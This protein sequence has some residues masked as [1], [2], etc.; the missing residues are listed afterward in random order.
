MTKVRLCEAL[1]IPFRPPPAAPVIHPERVCTRRRY[2]TYPNRYTRADLLAEAR[3][4]NIYV[5][6]GTTTRALCT[7]LG[8]PYIS[9]PVMPRMRPVRAPDAPGPRNV[10]VGAG[11]PSH[12]PGGCITR[13][14]LPLRAHQ[15]RVIEFMERSQRKGMMLFHKVGSGKTLTAIVASQCYLDRHPDGRVLV[16]TPTSLK[17]NFLKEME[18]YASVRNAEFT[19]MEPDRAAMVSSSAARAGACR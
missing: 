19:L 11:A 2:R 7:R 1:G 6:S 14:G 15:R 12:A 5:R 4:R 13:S 17:S 3:R 8:I 16:L 18:R 10:F 9:L